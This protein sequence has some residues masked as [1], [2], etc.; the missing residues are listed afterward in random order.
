MILHSNERGRER[1]RE[2]GREGGRFSENSKL[3]V[4][5]EE[6][7]KVLLFDLSCTFM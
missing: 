5:V 7:I 3:F 6:K 1:E 2:G 4:G